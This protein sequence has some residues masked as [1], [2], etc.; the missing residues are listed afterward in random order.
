[1]DFDAHLTAIAAARGFTPDP[2]QRAAA[3]ALAELER[4]LRR[5]PRRWSPGVYLHGPVGR[6]K[7]FLADAF[8][9]AMDV[10]RLRVSFH[11]F[12]DTLHDTTFRLGS[13]DAAIERHVKGLRL[14][15]FDEFQVDDPGDAALLTR[16]L[17]VLRER[18]I[19][20]VATS[21]H[22]PRDLLPNPLYHHLFLP[23]IALIKECTTVVEVHGPHDYRAK[24]APLGRFAGG[25]TY[26]DKPLWTPQP[27]EHERT[28]LPCG[29][30]R[31]LDA[32]AV[33]GR[34]AWFDFAEL[35]ERP[36]SAKDYLDLAER[37]DTWVISGVRPARSADGWQR[38]AHLIDI[39]YDRDI[40]LY[41][42]ADR[43]LPELLRDSPTGTERTASRLSLLARTSD[44]SSSSLR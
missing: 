17:R 13:A 10:A 25:Y 16:L 15:V 43:P 1:M 31:T 32:L 8:H 38:F 33:R 39:L 28:R 3:T 37:F 20:L 12:F 14:L 5:R 42:V 21:N 18:R 26:D 41:L 24:D 4:R 23:G 27:E 7:T 36:L 2:A 6:G 35:C 19:S 11:E 22:H 40:A 34:E 44:V 29:G 30:G 9:A